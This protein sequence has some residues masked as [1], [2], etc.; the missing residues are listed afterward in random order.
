M[1]RLRR[2][3]QRLERIS[4]ADS[5][6]GDGE[7]GSADAS[8]AREKYRRIARTYDLRL[9]TG[10]GLHRRAVER[11]EPRRGERVIDVGCGTGLAFDLIEKGIGPEGHL[12]G[13]ELSPEMLR[14]AR[15]RIE[16]HGWRNVTLIEGTAQ[17]AELPG[18]LDAALFVITHDIMRS[19]DALHNV[20]EAVHSG[21]RVVACGSKRPP[22]WLW[23]LRAYVEL[24][25]R[26]YVTTLEGFD[27][28][29]TILAELIPDL[30]V[31]S[32]FFGGAYLAWGTKHAGA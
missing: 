10:R 23:P 12:I 25:A 31:E 6:S 13:L 14:R 5:T 2:R 19:R 30:Q 15:R 22:G 28:P 20:M 29:W 21:G 9:T 11:L 26:R 7:I 8:E 24:K 32:M 16:Q 27:R 4:L 1:R 17:E 3:S 18:G